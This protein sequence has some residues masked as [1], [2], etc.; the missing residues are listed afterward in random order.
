MERYDWDVLGGWKWSTRELFSD[1]VLARFGSLADYEAAAARF[2][3]ERAKGV[4]AP[5]DEFSVREQVR[6]ARTVS[7]ATEERLTAALDSSSPSNPRQFI[8]ARLKTRAKHF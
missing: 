2:E 8:Y 4:L 3:A 5:L 1:L 7:F 6:L